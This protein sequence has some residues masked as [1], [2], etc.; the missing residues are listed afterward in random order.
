MLEV[1]K[2]IFKGVDTIEVKTVN[3]YSDNNTVI[4]E[5]EILIDKSSKINVV[6][7]ISFDEEGKILSITAYK[8]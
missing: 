8:G 3:I 2:K 7:I 4:S 6:D 1:N 5:I